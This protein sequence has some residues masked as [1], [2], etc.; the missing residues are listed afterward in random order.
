MPI[1]R[2]ALLPSVLLGFGLLNAHALNPIHDAT[3][4]FVPAFIDDTERD[5]VMT[6]EGYTQKSDQKLRAPIAY[7]HAFNSDFQMGVGLQT[8]WY[9]EPNNFREVLLGARYRLSQAWAFQADAL[10]GVANYAGDGL[11]LTGMYLYEPYSSLHI[12]GTARAGFFDALVW[13][14]DF[15]VVSGSV[16]PELLLNDY[17]R[18]DLEVFTAMQPQGIS[19]YFG[20]DLIPSLVYRYSRNLYFEAGGA[21]GMAGPNKSSPRF[22]LAQKI[23]L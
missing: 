16:T 15:M 20:L 6:G 4:Q 10:G 13:H 8:R 7:M 9:K 17:F 1:S 14:P 12:T 5:A 18:F 19:K 11:S 3:V 23:M 2:S 21:F 22:Q